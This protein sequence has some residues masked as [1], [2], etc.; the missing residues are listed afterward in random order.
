VHPHSCPGRIESRNANLFSIWNLSSSSL[1]IVRATLSSRPRMPKRRTRP[2]ILRARTSNRSNSSVD[3]G[4]Q[5]YSTHRNS[6]LS[7]Q[8]PH[9]ALKHAQPTGSPYLPAHP[10]RDVRTAEG[11]TF[12]EPLRD[13]I[14]MRRHLRQVDLRPRHKLHG[15][16]EHLPNESWPLHPSSRCRTAVRNDHTDQTR[17][18]DS[19]GPVG[20]E[21]IWL[22]LL[23]LRS[24][25]RCRHLGLSDTEGKNLTFQE[26]PRI[27]AE[28]AVFDSGFEAEDAFKGT[29]IT[30]GL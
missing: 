24:D 14:P 1:K 29:R 2:A 27:C 16:V 28:V 26:T 5:R 8:P 3:I 4:A 6:P 9:L 30:I 21:G 12:R 20:S 15:R 22:I 17:G 25:V 19:T 13:D 10:A 18:L 23:A 7:H 11:S